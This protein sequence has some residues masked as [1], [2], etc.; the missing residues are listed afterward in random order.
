MTSDVPI[1][2]PMGAPVRL[3]LVR[4]TDAAPLAVAVERGLF[5]AEGVAAEIAV[6]PSWAN[7]ADKLAFG[8]LDGAVMLPPLALAMN[9]GLRR[10]AAPLI[11]P[12]AI[13]RN[14]N[15]VVLST[16][17]ADALGL[18]APGHP[19][20]AP[21]ADAMAVGARLRA[22]LA[23]RGPLRLAVV[24]GWSTHD[25]LLR[26][27]LSACGID[28]ARAVDMSVIPPPQ[29]PH[30]LAEGRVDG[31]CAGA[32]WAAVAARAGSGRTIV[33]SSAIW[34]DHPEKCLVM[35]EDVAAARPGLVRGVVRALLRAGAICDDPAATAGIAAVLE[36]PDWLGLPAPLITGSLPGGADPALDRSAFA[37]GGGMYPWRSHA[38]WF[39]GQ[40]ARW[41]PLPDD[42]L[43][44]AE[45]TYRPD[46][47]IDAAAGL[48][49]TG[50]Y[51][52][53][54]GPFCDEAG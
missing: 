52:R 46:L 8:L 13:S 49:S 11:V 22:L 53:R 28:P 9:I 43:A 4:L 36:G 30:A 38:A 14:G 31:F 17:F 1:G 34:R 33:R 18:P 42:A 25:L 26:Y 51:A 50:P 3:G 39:V 5:A 20:A 16:A 48:G 7:V 47:F 6:E 24:H 21:A 44:R 15:S 40:M 12:M 37:A 32:P 35:R 10:A 45:A 41:A 29:M 54:D 23:A 27:W 19:E 2:A